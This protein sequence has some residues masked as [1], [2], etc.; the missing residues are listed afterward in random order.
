MPITK[1]IES[2]VLNKVESQEVYDY[3]ASK[4]LI[5]EDELYLVL[6]DASADI[7]VDA[8]LNTESENPVQNK[9]IA[10]AIN[11]LN[12][13]VGDTTVSLQIQNY[14]QNFVPKHTTIT[15]PAANWIGSSNPYSQVVTVNG[16]T[17]NSKIDLQPTALQVIALQNSDI[18]LMA[19]NDDGVITVYALG[20]KPTADYTMQALITEVVAV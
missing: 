9:V 16:A 8:A 2:L 10:S 5:N 20:G 1:N 19:D 7:I 15:L 11:N 12:T 13:L 4:N 6:G 17:V 14:I 3:M 18:A